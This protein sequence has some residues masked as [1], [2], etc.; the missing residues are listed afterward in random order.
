MTEEV[1]FAIN[2]DVLGPPDRV[3]GIDDGDVELFDENGEIRIKIFINGESADLAK[4]SETTITAKARPV[5]FD[6][7]LNVVV[8][9]KSKKLINVLNYDRQEKLLSSLFREPLDDDS[10]L[11]N[12]IETAVDK[13]VTAIPSDE[14]LLKAIN[15]IVAAINAKK[16]AGRLPPNV[17]AKKGK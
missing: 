9:T 17:S 14:L 4:T 5:L 13:I 3:F 16:R 6:D 8:T 15:H 12:T 1:T 10:N 2:R 11:I 7:K